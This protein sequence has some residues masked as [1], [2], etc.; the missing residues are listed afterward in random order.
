MLQHISLQEFLWFFN[1]MRIRVFPLHNQKKRYVI[2]LLFP[3]LSSEITNYRVFYR[4]TAIYFINLSK[5]VQKLSFNDIYCCPTTKKTFQLKII[6]LKFVK[7]HTFRNLSLKISRE[8]SKY[9]DEKLL[10][11]SPKK[12]CSKI[13]VFPLQNKKK[14][15]MPSTYF[16]QNWA[17]TIK[18]Y[19]KI[20][21]HLIHLYR[22][23][24]IMISQ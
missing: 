15:G 24:L 10:F 5:Q 22:R 16:F 17:K 19:G 2:E 6:C 11:C 4:T 14:I 20:H 8:T 7:F 23:N 3:E 12:F 18:N 13:Q 21:T 1:M 9:L